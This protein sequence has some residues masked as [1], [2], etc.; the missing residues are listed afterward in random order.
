MK[1][2]KKIGWFD[3]KKV[4]T[5]QDILKHVTQKPLILK[6]LFKH[7]MRFFDT[8]KN[9]SSDDKLLGK[10]SCLEMKIFD[11]LFL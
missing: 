5:T 2:I 8:Q 10:G 11:A 1:K 4:H 3:K 6:A 9:V 7:K